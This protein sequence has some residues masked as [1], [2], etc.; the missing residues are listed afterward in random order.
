MSLV[1]N[2]IRASA[3]NV[4]SNTS[5]VP[6]AN[7]TKQLS[8]FAVVIIGVTIFVSIGTPV[9]IRGLQGTL[10][11]PQSDV[12]KS[13][14]RETAFFPVAVWYSGG[15]AR[16]PMLETITPDSA[17]LWEEDLSKIKQLGFNTVRTWVE[18]NVA[19]PQEGKYHLENLDLLL[20]LANEVDLKVIVQVYVDSALYGASP[21]R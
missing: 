11:P 8:S 12:A 1:R 10:L 5:P 21:R 9:R 19:E 16:A 17:G 13:K 4:S 6:W 7:L 20:R 18:W 15:K 2:S 3:Y 14:G